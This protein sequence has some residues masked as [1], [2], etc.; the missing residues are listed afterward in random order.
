[1]LV[2]GGLEQVAWNNDQP[3]VQHQGNYLDGSITSAKHHNGNIQSIC[4]LRK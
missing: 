3:R 2:Q 4:H 1:M